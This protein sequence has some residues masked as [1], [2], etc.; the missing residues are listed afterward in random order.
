MVF[1]GETKNKS[2]L[3]C[4]TAQMAYD[5]S[6]IALKYDFSEFFKIEGAPQPMRYLKLLQDC[7]HSNRK[8]QYQLPDPELL[9]LINNTNLEENAKDKYN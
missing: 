4:S 2:I 3:H 7:V 5:S 6:T 9:Y 8:L 1:D